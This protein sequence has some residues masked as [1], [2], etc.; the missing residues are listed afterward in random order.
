MTPL[1]ALLAAAPGHAA[2]LAWEGFYRARALRF[3]SLSLSE[4]N[5][6]AEGVSSMM[7]HRLRLEPRWVIDDRAQLHAQLDGLAYVP[8]GATSDRYTPADSNVATPLALT[9]GVAAESGSLTLTRAWGDVFTPWGRL[10]FGRMPLQWGAGVLWNPG[11]DPLSE[12]GDTSDRVSF[13]SRVG[14][15]FVMGAVDRIAEGSVNEPDDMIGYSAAV[16]FRSETNGIGLLNNVRTQSS[17]DWISYTGDFW[18]MSDLGPAQL[19]LEVVGTYG[20]GKLDDATTDV[21]VLAFGGMLDAGWSADKVGLGVQGG[22]ATGDEDPTDSDLT[23]F[24]F[25][26]DHNVALM[27]FEE[28]MPTLRAPVT[29]EDNAGRTQQAALIGEGVRNALYVKPRV[30]YRLGTVEAELAW[31][32]GRMM[33]GPASTEG[34][35]GYGNEVDLTARWAVSP[36][37]QLQGTLGVYAPGSYLTTATDAD[38]GTGFDQPAVGARV[39]GTVNF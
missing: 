6:N 1:L 28:A 36:H 14:A 5:A 4:D 7:D 20:G 9:D 15:L 2:D 30:S 16:G 26:R 29:T 27:M 33:S 24:A 31:I 3:D 22:F 17:N 10:S 34:R 21:S 37:A 13:T 18:A 32:T 12:Y 8:F 35:R 39:V 25:D 19:Q 38:L 11:N 23:T